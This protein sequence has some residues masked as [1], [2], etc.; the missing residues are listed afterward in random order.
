MWLSGA[1]ALMT[2]M[3]NEGRWDTSNVVFDS[4]RVVVYDKSRPEELRPRMRW[5]DYGLSILTRAVV[6]DSIE[7]GAVEDLAD[8]LRGLSV[9]EQLAGF[10]VRERF[11]EV[12][13]PEG[14]KDLE[15][16]L[17][18]ERMRADPA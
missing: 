7:P 15:A 1:A 3:R 4:G 13:S 18:L 14:L 2:V 10:E 16:H 6:S 11:Y 8:L 17:S 12:G 5:I 9:R